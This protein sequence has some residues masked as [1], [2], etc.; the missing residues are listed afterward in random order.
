MADLFSEP[1]EEDRKPPAA[2]SAPQ[3]RIVTVSELTAAIRGLLETGFGDIWVDGEISNCRVW[4]TGHLYFTLKDGGAQ[5]KAVMFRSAV[6]YLKFKPEDGLPGHRARPARRLRTQ[7]G[8]PVRLRAS[9]AARAGRAAARLRAAEEE[10]AG[11][12]AVRSGAQAAAAGAAAQDRHRDVARGRGPPRHHQGAA[13]PPSQRA[14]RDPAGA[15]A[16]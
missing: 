2:P 16:G 13:A 9:R 8:V 1:F 10:A 4:N 3:R 12:R 7:G 5:I 6:R 14:S 11:R 15:R